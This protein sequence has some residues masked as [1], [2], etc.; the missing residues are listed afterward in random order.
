MI[1][2]SQD[3]LSIILFFLDDF[4]IRISYQIRII[5]C[6]RKNSHTN[7]AFIDSQNLNLGIKHSGW[8]L[9]FQKFRRYLQEKYSVIKA[10]VFIGYVPGNEGLYTNLQ[11]MGYICIFKPTL[12]LKD[13]QVKGNV[14]AELVLHTMIQFN[15]F[16]KAVIVSGDGDFYCLIEY[17]LKENKLERLL[18]PNETVYSALFKRLSRQEKN[19]FEF[20]NR[21][22]NTLELK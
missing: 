21:K 18:V 19:I 5:A 12:Q 13:G 9:D 16:D 14:D 6:M 1:Y 20:L 10:Y 17:L 2:R 3:N 15:N 11:N 7:F 22:R 4:F 8:R